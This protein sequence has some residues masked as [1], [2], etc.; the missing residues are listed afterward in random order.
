MI[1]KIFNGIDK[2]YINPRKTLNLTKNLESTMKLYTKRE[3]KFF[4]MLIVVA[5]GGDI[6]AAFFFL[7]YILF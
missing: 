6:K 7:V 4:K 3:H 2:V 5:L 1:F